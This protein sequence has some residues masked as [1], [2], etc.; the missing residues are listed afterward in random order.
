MPKAFELAVD[1]VSVAS[2][3]LSHLSVQFLK[4]MSKSV[5]FSRKL[6]LHQFHRSQELKV[7]WKPWVLQEMDH[8][9]SSAEISRKRPGKCWAIWLNKEIWFW[10]SQ[11]WG[12]LPTNKKT[13]AIPLDCASA[14]SSQLTW[15][16]QYF[17]M[18]P[19]FRNQFPVCFSY[20]SS[21]SFS[22]RACLS[23]EVKTLFPLLVCH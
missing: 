8:L 15:L 23:G 5:F 3:L 6:L 12:T 7:Q 1:E 19:C 22:I 16:P 4:Y 18:I 17:T 9:K 11:C 20:H 2:S 21:P 13:P 10:S 14:L